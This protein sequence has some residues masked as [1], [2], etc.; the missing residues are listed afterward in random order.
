MNVIYHPEAE[1]EMIVAANYYET[2][3]HGLG[4]KFL[5]DLD[6]TVEDI[7]KYPETWFTLED[8]IQRHQFTH[9]PFAILY[10]IVGLRIRILAVMD[11]HK[12]PAY[13]KNRI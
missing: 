10:R 11:L 8:N 2:K 6:E 1:D 7:V 4:T 9:F 13:W 5:N 3:V 12:K